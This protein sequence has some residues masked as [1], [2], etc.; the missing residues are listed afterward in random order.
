M[1]ISNFYEKWLVLNDTIFIVQKP[2]LNKK[3]NHKISLILCFCNNST[4]SVENFIRIDAMLFVLLNVLYSHTST[5]TGKFPELRLFLDKFVNH[6]F[7]NVLPLSKFLEN[8][9]F[10]IF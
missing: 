1:N 8:A 5:K 10:G 6:Q 3:K 9:N 7:E 2:F 4:T